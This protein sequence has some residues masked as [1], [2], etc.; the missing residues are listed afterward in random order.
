MYVASS[1]TY[2]EGDSYEVWQSGI[3]QKKLKH[4]AVCF[5]QKFHCPFHRS[6]P[7]SSWAIRDTSLLSSRLSAQSVEK[8]WNLEPLISHLL[9]FSRTILHTA[10]NY[11]S[12]GCPAARPRVSAAADK[13]PEV[14][15]RIT[16]RLTW[17]WW[18]W[19]S[20]SLV[21]SFLSHKPLFVQATKSLEKPGNEAMFG[22][23]TWQVQSSLIVYF[24][25]LFSVTQTSLDP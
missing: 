20:Y 15:R 24:I 11:W 7:F 12:G 14:S 3:G 6:S 8:F 9:A 22:T 5:T 4:S 10:N 1:L 23:A 19:Y 18:V 17:I 13:W 2:N 16:R 25:P 21:P